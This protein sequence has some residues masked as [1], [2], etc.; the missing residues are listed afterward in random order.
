M[1]QQTLTVD[2]GGDVEARADLALGHRVHQLRQI[3]GHSTAQR[4][5]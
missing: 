1:T 3:V 4:E 5:W 2:R